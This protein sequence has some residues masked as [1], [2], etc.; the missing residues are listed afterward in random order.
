M[1]KIV[2][3]FLVFVFVMAI[4]VDAKRL[5]YT[6]A[7][8]LPYSIHTDNINNNPDDQVK[9]LKELGLLEETDQKFNLDKNITR[10]EAAEM[11]AYFLGEAGNVQSGKWTHPFTD[12]PK[13]ADKYIGWMY[14]SGLTKGI[15]N[16]KYGSSQNITYKE[17]ATLLSRALAGNDDFLSS[18]IG[19][20]EEQE[21]SESNRIFLNGSAV[22]LFTRALS[23]YY[24]KNGKNM[25]VA[26][27]LIQKG[28]FT[29]EQFGEASWGV[30]GS[31]YPESL[32]NNQKYLLRSVAD[33][34]VA[35]CTEKDLYI[36]EDSINSDL[37]YIYGSRATGNQ[38]LEVFKIDCKTLEAVSAGKYESEAC[39]GLD[40]LGSSGGNDYLLERRMLKSTYS[41]SVICMDGNKLSVEVP[42]SEL[43]GD[44]APY[45]GQASILI[46]EDSLALRGKNRL[47]V[48]SKNHTASHEIPKDTELL[49][50]DGESIVT[51][52]ITKAST[53][54]SCI[55]AANGSTLNRYE[56]KQD[57]AEYPR[58]ISDKG[59]GR[60]FGEA[61][62]Y[63]IDT[64]TGRLEQI[65]DRPVADI[66]GYRND[67]RPI[68]LTHE[69]GKRIFGMHGSLGGD[70]IIMI[71][72]D[73]T[74]KVL[75]GN[76]PDLNLPIAEF[77]HGSG[78]SVSFQVAYG[79]GMEVYDI[80]YYNL[81]PDGSIYVMGFT[82]GRTDSLYGFGS[83]EQ[84]EISR[85]HKEQARLDA[86]GF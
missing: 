76:V 72:D 44:A 39:V 9:M 30:L 70:Q 5:E 31:T 52:L 18:G 15:G 34:P 21:L 53:I 41:G 49:Y 66:T 13:W 22:G 61:G 50:F 6:N 26:Q 1:K 20:K 32:D 12:V 71:E 58:T 25:R 19:I 11:L 40:Y 63:Q 68:I 54:I 84:Y 14:Q 47:F 80:Y 2:S 83:L 38:A 3:L 43:W 57:M 78:S 36:S 28:V 67:Y 56:V 60:L 74:E 4:P 73:G 17:F 29:T 27:F 86:L 62:L 75:L 82:A 85:V 81:L 10:C 45:A 8:F 48:I 46:A 37:E 59:Y 51:Q 79:V 35:K 16:K 24:T 33:V 77:G 23:C 55:D 69:L 7:Y 65:T 42:A 64:K